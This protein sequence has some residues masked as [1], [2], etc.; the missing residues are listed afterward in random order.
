MPDRHLTA[1]NEEEKALVLKAPVLVTL[2]IAGADQNVSAKE[3]N[4]AKKVIHYRTFTENQRLHDYYEAVSEGFEDTLSQ[5]LEGDAAHLSEAHLSGELARLTD[6]LPKMDKTYAETLLKSLRSLANH[7]AEAD[8][9]LLGFHRVGVDEQRL[10]D[11]PM[12][13]Y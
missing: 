8:G 10:V 2:L 7:I 5:H 12:I 4:W 13:Q 3:V 6:I 11:L 1:L 9:G